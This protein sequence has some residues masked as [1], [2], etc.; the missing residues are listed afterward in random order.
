MRPVDRSN[1]R[2]YV[3]GEV[4]DGWHLLARQDLSVIA[5]RVPPGARETTHRHHRARQFFYILEGDAVLELQGTAVDLRA[6]QGLEVEPGTLHRF[7]NDSDSDVHF[8]VISM[9]TTRGDREDA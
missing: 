1:A 2:H 7:R 6:G 9:P 3:W 4:C 5:E 8:L